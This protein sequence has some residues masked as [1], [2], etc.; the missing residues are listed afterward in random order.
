MGDHVV[1]EFYGNTTACLNVMR[2]GDSS[3][4]VRDSS[5]QLFKGIVHFLSL[6]HIISVQ[7]MLLIVPGGFC[8]Q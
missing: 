4:W 8:V 2:I 7:C 1:I 6:F 5:N 3:N